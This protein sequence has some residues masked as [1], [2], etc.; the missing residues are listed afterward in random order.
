[1][2]DMNEA[3]RDQCHNQERNQ[4]AI[5]LHVNGKKVRTEDG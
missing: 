1:M 2:E 4:D 5:K 3:V